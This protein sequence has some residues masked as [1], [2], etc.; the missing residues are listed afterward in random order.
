MRTFSASAMIAAALWAVPAAAQDKIPV[1]DK[2]DVASKPVKIHS[3]MP[4]SC[5]DNIRNASAKFN[6]AGAN[7]QFTGAT[8]YY[9]TNWVN[10]DNT[11]EAYVNIQPATMSPY[12]DS[13]TLMK[14]YKYYAWFDG[15][16]WENYYELIDAN[17][18]V[19]DTYIMYAGETAR[20]KDLWCEAAT[21]G[22]GNRS[23]FESVIIHEFGHAAGMEHRTDGTTGPCVM[24]ASY[25]PGKIR[26]TFCTDEIAK[27]KIVYGTR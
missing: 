1:N 26:R 17:I 6:Q 11:E 18:Y 15:F 25:S 12:T 8:N 22:I 7:F 2:F 16:V 13:T 19:N 10:N 3:S 24:T 14:T 23:D 4:I 5:D 21:T 9:G 20:E 27:L